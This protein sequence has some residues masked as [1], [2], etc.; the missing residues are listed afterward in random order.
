MIVHDD[1]STDGTTD[2]VNEYATNYPK[3]IKPVI[4]TENQWQRG[5]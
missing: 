4:E 5:G 2:I 3:I 1:A